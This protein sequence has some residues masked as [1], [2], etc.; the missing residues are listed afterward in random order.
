MI[1]TDGHTKVFAAFLS[2]FKEINAYW[3]TDEL[4]WE[5]YE[6]CV[7]WCVEEGIRSVADLKDKVVEFEDFEALWYKRCQA[8]HKTLEEKRLTS[9]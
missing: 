6:I 3:E 1:L 2:G 5:A 9:A 4:D 8:M 7:D